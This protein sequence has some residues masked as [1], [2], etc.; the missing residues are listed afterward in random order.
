MTQTKNVSYKI[1]ARRDKVR[2]LRAR[3]LTQEQIAK[4]MEVSRSTIKRDLKRIKQNTKKK[5]DENAEEEVL[6]MIE[7]QL[8]S[9]IDEYWLDRHKKGSQSALN[10]IRKAVNDYAR[11]LQKLG[12]VHEEPSK[13]EV[14]EDI[15]INIGSAPDDD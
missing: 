7:T 1:S 8:L 15:K 4:N 13:H 10:G 14:K 6:D 9:I 11:N 12:F 3:G 2:K 5:F